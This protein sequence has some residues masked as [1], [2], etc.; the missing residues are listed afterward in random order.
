MKPVL[1]PEGFHKR[2][3]AELP[4]LCIQAGIHPSYVEEHLD[5][6]CTKSECDWVRSFLTNQKA[7]LRG[8]VLE[9]SKPDTRCQA[10]AACLLRN[11][12]DARVISLN[13]ILE[14]YEEHDVPQPTLL[15]IPNL[16]VTVTGKGLPGWRIQAIYDI[17][18]QRISMGKPSV[19]YVEDMTSLKQAYGMPFFDLL[20]NFPKVTA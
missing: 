2:L 18:M 5:K 19:L 20:S 1:D 3:L 10:I 16:Y 8:L 13:N 15:L 9:G 11:Y 17:L 14:R 12:V 6:Y 7:Y 4:R